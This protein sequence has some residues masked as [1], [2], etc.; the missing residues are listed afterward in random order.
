M[1]LAIVGDDPQVRALLPALVVLRHDVLRLPATSAS[2]ALM[3]DITIAIV[4]ATGPDL[5]TARE[6]CRHI[7]GVNPDLPVAALVTDASLP[8]IDGSWA[9][10]DFLMAGAP[11][12]EI[13]ARFRLLLSRDPV[14][15]TD[16]AEAAVLELGDLVIDEHT[17]TARLA[18]GHLDLTYKEYE[19]L[20]FLVRHVEHVHTREQLLDEVWGA[21]YRGGTRTVDVHVRRLRMKL[22][23]YGR[24]IVTVRNVGYKV[25]HPRP[26]G[27]AANGGANGGTPDRATG[28]ATGRA[29]DRATDRAI[30]DE[31]KQ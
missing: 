13:E 28:R 16:A 27:T 30:D 25:I 4:D 5:L 6:L 12:D 1:R 14:P 18:D 15:V 23:D 21:D 2:A 31:E 7:A 11:A 9:I 19:L 24:V 3:E 29:T 20:R 17:Y 8:A 26:V 22:G 10:D